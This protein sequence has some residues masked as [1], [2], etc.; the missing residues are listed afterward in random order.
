MILYSDQCEPAKDIFTRTDSPEVVVLR[1]D[2]RCKDR[3]SRKRPSS[4]SLNL[5]WSYLPPLLASQAPS[6]PYCDTATSV[7]ESAQHIDNQAPYDRTP[8]IQGHLVTH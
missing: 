2:V 5:R 1:F 6:C 4:V 7:S 3:F 8:I